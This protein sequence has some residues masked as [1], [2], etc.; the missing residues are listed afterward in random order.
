MGYVWGD[1]GSTQNAT[2][3]TG[4]AY[5]AANRMSSRVLHPKVLISLRCNLPTGGL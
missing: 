1:Q 2:Q 3:E 5:A 4:G